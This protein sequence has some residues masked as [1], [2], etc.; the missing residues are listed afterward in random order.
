M[1]SQTVLSGDEA[2]TAATL[3][4]FLCQVNADVVPEVP[5]SLELF[6]TIG[7]LE[8]ER[9]IFVLQGVVSLE[10][11]QTEVSNVGTEQT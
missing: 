10:I 5:P 7:T 9:G 1:S 6:Q 8:S 4:G 2:Q 3:E 11:L